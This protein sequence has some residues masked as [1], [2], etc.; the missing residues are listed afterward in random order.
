MVEESLEA[1]AEAASP[2]H[3]RARSSE[4]WHAFLRGGWWVASH[5]FRHGARTLVAWS[6]EPAPAGEVLT[7]GELRI[8]S[9]R[10][11]GDSLKALAMDAGCSPSR[12]TEGLKSAS[13][14]LRIE[15]ESD[16]VALF[17]AWPDAMAVRLLAG[18]DGRRLVLRYAP[19]RWCAPPCLTKTEAEI[20]GA[21]VA[22]C[23]HACIACARGVSPRT[24]AN[25]V[26]A[27]HQ[28]LKVG[29]R[30]ELFAALRAR[31]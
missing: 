27:I 6:K 8:A 25:Q 17:G 21:L 9:L 3:A 7:A 5:A 28:K 2:P 4:A 10:A 31:G 11:Q 19:P 18:D 1:P 13:R 16:L 15:R 26:A 30:V 14:K 20:V 24:I 29:S 22:G 12:I 23:S